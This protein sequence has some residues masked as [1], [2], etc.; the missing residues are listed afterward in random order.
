MTVIELVRELGVTKGEMF[1]AAQELRLGVVRMSA[2]LNSKQE[3][4]LRNHFDNIAKAHR[5]RA[6]RLAKERAS[7]PRAS[8]ARSAPVPVEHEF[9]K[10]CL[11]CARRWLLTAV[12]DY[13]TP[14]CSR[15]ESH[16]PIPDEPI[17]RRLERAETHASLYWE[18]RDGARQSASRSARAAGVAYESRA[19]WVA[20]LVEVVLDHDEGEDG[21]C[22]CGEQ[23]PCRTWRKLEEANKG[24][25]R[26]VEKW[27]SWSR[28]RLDEFLYGDDRAN[29]RVIDGDEPK[30]DDTVATA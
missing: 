29:R 27:G 23:Y 20:A 5:K 9:T 6:A 17:D 15:C 8:P 18:E 21:L 24:I 30:D 26:D 4:R 10:T 14:L 7:I 16:S 2:Q 19:K 28:K 25:H 22:W 12:E 13:S 1:E 11:C 3:D